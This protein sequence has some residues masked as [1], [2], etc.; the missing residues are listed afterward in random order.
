MIDKI[1]DILVP[2]KLRGKRMSV[3]ME[4]GV[5]IVFLVVV[6]VIAIERILRKTIDAI[7]DTNQWSYAIGYMMLYL[8][9]TVLI[10]GLVMGGINMLISTISDKK[11]E[12]VVITRLC[13]SA[14]AEAFSAHIVVTSGIYPLQIH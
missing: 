10:Y 2:V 3:L 6:A 4:R 11:R 13:R 7:G 14:Q 8:F 12:M 1:L 5:K 9:I